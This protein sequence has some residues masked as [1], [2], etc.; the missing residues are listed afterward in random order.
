MGRRGADAASH[1]EVG[2]AHGACSYGAQ[3]SDL[4]AEML[5]GDG[6]WLAHLRRGWVQ[7]WSQGIRR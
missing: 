1:Y 5:G 3:V 2:E 6:A 4:G 7:L